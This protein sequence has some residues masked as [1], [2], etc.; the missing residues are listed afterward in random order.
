MNKQRKAIKNGTKLRS[1]VTTNGVSIFTCNQTKSTTQGQR[2]SKQGHTHTIIL[3]LSSNNTNSCNNTSINHNSDN[4]SNNNNNT[5][6]S[7]NNISNNNAKK[8]IIKDDNHVSDQEI[9]EKIDYNLIQL[10]SNSNVRN[11]SHVKVNNIHDNSETHPNIYN[12]I[13]FYERYKSC[14]MRYTCIGNDICPFECI[15]CCKSLMNGKASNWQKLVYN[16]FINPNCNSEHNWKPNSSCRIDER[17]RR[18]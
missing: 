13:E 3:F 11:D 17:E 1:S 4:I 15:V 2:E 12:I 9:I 5:A 14:A 8:D 16:Q 6:N 7:N 18:Y 10:S